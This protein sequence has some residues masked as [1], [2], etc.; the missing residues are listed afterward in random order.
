MIRF[1]HCK[2]LQLLSLICLTP[3]DFQAGALL[4]LKLES[5]DKV[6]CWRLLYPVDLS[7]NLQRS[8]ELKSQHHITMIMCTDYGR[9][10][11]KYSSLNGR[12]FNPNPKFLGTA[13]AYFVCH[14]G[15]IFQISLIYA[16]IGCPQSVI[17]CMRWHRSSFKF[18]QMCFNLKWQLF[19]IK[20]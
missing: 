13:K 11:R 1:L 5:C 19:Q 7:D 14:I 8:T 4:L 18:F 10:E 20:K 15:P 2:R 6:V 3:Q 16:F 12:K 9:P 17:M